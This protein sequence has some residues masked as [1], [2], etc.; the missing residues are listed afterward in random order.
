MKS[1]AYLFRRIAS[2]LA[3]TALGWVT[4]A[5]AAGIQQAFLVQTPAGWS[6]LH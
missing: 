2:A 1:P 4:P 5:A 3:L 6:L